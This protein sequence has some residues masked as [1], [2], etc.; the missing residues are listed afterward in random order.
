MADIIRTEIKP[1]LTIE[2]STQALDFT[3]DL[4]TEFL[5]RNKS[6]I[7]DL[8]PTSVG[9]GLLDNLN[10]GCIWKYVGNSDPA[11]NKLCLYPVLNSVLQPTPIITI[12]LSTLVVTFNKDT[13]VTNT[14]SGSYITV[15]GVDTKLQ[16]YAT[17]TALNS[18]ATAL[19]NS[20][21][22]YATQ[23]WVNNKNYITS[24]SVDVDNL[25]KTGDA[26]APSIN[27]KQT[28]VA[29]GDYTNANITVDAFGRI[30]QAANGSSGNSTSNVVTYKSVTTTPYSI[31]ANDFF[32][33]VSA[34]TTAINLLLPSTANTGQTYKVMDELGTSATNAINILGNVSNFNNFV[35][36][37]TVNAGT[38]PWGVVVTPNGKYAYVIN[39]DSNN[40]TV[41][42]N[43]DTNTPIFLKNITVGS[44]PYALQV[45]PNGN[46][47][48][49]VNANSNNVS[50]IQNASTDNPT[51]QKTM[52]VG[53]L[54]ESIV[55]T[56]D[57]SH[58]FVAN[59]NTG[60]VSVFYNVS[61]SAQSASAI[62]VGS[63]PY[64]MAVTPNGNYVYVNNLYSSSVSII[65]DA[66][67]ASLAPTLLTTLTVGTNP[68]CVV[69]TPNGN[70]AYVLCYGSNN[71]YVIQNAST[72]TPT[73]WGVFSGDFQISYLSQKM[74][75]L[76]PDG[77]YL[78][79]ANCNSTTVSVYKNASTNPTLL[80]TLTTGTYSNAICFSLDGKIAYVMNFQYI[81][82]VIKNANTDS[83]IVVTNLNLQTPISNPTT[84]PAGKI[85][86]F[87][88]N[89]KVYFS[90]LSTSLKTN[91]SSVSLIYNGSQW[92]AT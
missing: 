49:V 15:S 54:P 61:S 67:S 52:S 43:V 36:L 14:G 83:P 84:E 25:V 76:S 31:L 75:A 45:S 9:A 63:T 5:L 29:A 18:F 57:G 8:V 13:Q 20:L 80:T 58:A 1:I 89:G 74:M 91:N 66:S 79:I 92:L 19:T 30:T 26:V 47:V 2:G 4:E 60:G 82:S 39:K 34:S 50:V 41:I 78:Y 40:V 72:D 21:T 11:L 68:Y 48:Y 77:N 55:I 69:I 44:A 70:Y 6:T 73:V 56:P 88:Q 33:G 10:N 59:T 51:I 3:N 64:S 7:T 32:I 35:T 27:L 24:I 16:N 22:N 87:G 37:A 53:S 90:S 65:K 81:M 23:Q 71:I 12:N 62:A 38:L 85:I 17:I 42:K 46:L 86:T 28:A